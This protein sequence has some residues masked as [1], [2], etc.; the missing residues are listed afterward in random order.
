[1]IYLQMTMTEE[2]I[3]A[4]EDKYWPVERLYPDTNPAVVQVALQDFSPMEIL[5]ALDDLDDKKNPEPADDN[6]CPE[7]GHDWNYCDCSPFSDSDLE[8]DTEFDSR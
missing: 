6:L 7:C 3:L 4:A 5:N 1:M 8:P 2:E